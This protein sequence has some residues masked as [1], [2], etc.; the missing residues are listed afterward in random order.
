MDR[1][2][3][4]IIYYSIEF[5]KVIKMVIIKIEDGVYFKNLLLLI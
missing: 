3:L 5:N 4:K 1:W 2:N